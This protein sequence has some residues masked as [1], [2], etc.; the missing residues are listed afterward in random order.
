[1]SIA[2]KRLMLLIVSTLL[3]W[4][5]QYVYIPFQTPY[6]ESLHAGPAYIGVIV[7]AYGLMQALLRLPLGLFADRYRRH[8]LFI[9]LGVACAALASVARLIGG[10]PAAFLVGNV[11]S[12]VAS[13]SWI[14]FA[15]YYTTLFPPE[16]ATKALGY[17]VA[18]TNVG[19]LAAFIVGTYLYRIEGMPPVLVAS[20][21]AGAMGIAVALLLREDKP[22]PALKPPP[23]MVNIIR[24]RRLWYYSVLSLC[25]QVIMITTA[26]SF[27]SSYLKQY[28]DSEV[29]L[30]VSAA[31]FIAAA[32]LSALAV[33]HIRRT[34]KWTSSKALLTLFFALQL[35]YCA[36]MPLCTQAWQICGLQAVCGLGNGAA[37]SLLMALAMEGVDPQG[38]S[39]AMGFY[40]AI[41]GIGSTVGPIIMGAL[42]QWS[43]GYMLGYWTL[44]GIALLSIV[45]VQFGEPR[46]ATL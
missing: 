14:S 21:A 36:L 7:G 12:G 23:R 17:S 19:I 11:L 3:L 24:S 4:F 18:A 9:V 37:M 26:L 46:G 1:M 41:Y 38:K 34:S 31:V 16:E 27:T 15:V 6:L 39:T 32:A 29:M 22:A 35:V 33:G 42:I 40:Q 20:I 30:G 44:A 2:R 8:K 13:A 10:T 28:T 45:A 25:L 5:A 43:D